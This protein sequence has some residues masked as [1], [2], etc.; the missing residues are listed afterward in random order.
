[1]YDTPTRTGE[2]QNSLTIAQVAERLQCS[3]DTVRREIARGRLKAIRFGRLIRIRESDL[4][5]AQRAVTPAQM[6]Y[7]GADR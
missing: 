2:S 3:P 5:R 1:M 7:S 4:A 6:A